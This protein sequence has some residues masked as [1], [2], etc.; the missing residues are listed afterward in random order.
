MYIF[1]KQYYR[2][3]SGQIYLRTY[4]HL[5]KTLLEIRSYKRQKSFVLGAFIEIV[6]YT[7]YAYQKGKN[8]LKEQHINIFVNHK[9]SN[10]SNENDEFGRRSL[11]A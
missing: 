2:T 7:K 5:D 9:H 11:L 3:I 8:A 10:I 6:F 4:L 1:Q